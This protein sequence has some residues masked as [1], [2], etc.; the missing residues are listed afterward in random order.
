MSF[1]SLVILIA[2]VMLHELGHLLGMMLFGYKD[3]K[4]LFLP[5][6]GAATIGSRRETKPYQRI[7]VSFLGPVPGIVAGL[8][9]LFIFPGG[10]GIIRETALMLLILN[11]I[12]LLPIM[13]LDGGQ[14][15]N[16]FIAKFPYFQLVFQIISALLFLLIFG[17]MSPVLLIIGVVLMTAAFS[18]MSICALHNRLRKNMERHG[19][20]ASD[21]QILRELF[22]LMNEKQYAQL[23]FLNKFQ[24]AKSLVDNYI[25]E[26]PSVWVIIAT[27]AFY[28]SLFVV[29]AVLY[30]I[31][32]V[33]RHLGS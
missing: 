28:V 21:E 13:P 32:L 17:F 30:I 7:I 23:P 4:I 12:N 15:F 31:S 27:F 5:F 3:L 22:G 33:L 11:Y 20:E 9:I 29:P 1:E 8:L 16:Q 10:N 2:V 24:I 26:P 14:I 18:T 25:A 19:S 6:L